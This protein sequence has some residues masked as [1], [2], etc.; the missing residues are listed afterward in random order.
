MCF[1][2]LNS[3]FCIENTMHLFMLYVAFSLEIGTEIPWDFHCFLGLKCSQNSISSMTLI[4]SW[5]KPRN[6]EVSKRLRNPL[7]SSIHGKLFSQG[8]SE[9]VLGEFQFSYL[10]LPTCGAL[11]HAAMMTAVTQWTRVFSISKNTEFLLENSSFCSDRWKNKHDF[12]EPIA[13]WNFRIITW[14][15]LDLNSN[16]C[17]KRSLKK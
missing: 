8:C 11:N 13:T 14:E 9:I 16:N 17:I 2:T 10:L 5:T 12:T 1:P 6:S 7:K 4:C 3:K 15:C